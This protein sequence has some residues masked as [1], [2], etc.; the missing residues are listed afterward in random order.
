MDAV[1][2]DFKYLTEDITI[3]NI[4]TKAKKEISDI[5][6]NARLHNQL[7]KDV[8]TSIGKIHINPYGSVSQISFGGEDIIDVDRF[9]VSR[10]LNIDSNNFYNIQKDIEEDCSNFDFYPIIYRNKIFY[11]VLKTS[12]YFRTKFG[13]FLHEHDILTVKYAHKY[14]IFSL[15][16]DGHIKDYIFQC[17]LLS[18][19]NTE[20]LC[21]KDAG[22]KF[23]CNT[24]LYYCFAS[25]SNYLLKIGQCKQD[26]IAYKESFDYYE[27]TVE[28]VVFWISRIR[29]NNSKIKMKDTKRKAEKLLIE[30]QY[31]SISNFCQLKK[32]VFKSL[33]S[34]FLG[35]MSD[36]KY[37]NGDILTPTRLIEI[38]NIEIDISDK[39]LLDR[40]LLKAILY[41]DIPDL[42]W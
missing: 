8:E 17:G 20:Q 6:L 31:D 13:F 2:N 11:T 28:S 4:I 39:G 12:K 26:F 27:G 38:L 19:E 9:I 10:S 22:K 29:D 37:E 35:E 42:C 24:N 23:G 3:S 40:N 25:K 32:I 7:D 15:N 41:S 33:S 14:I 21:L 18:Q 5:L 30:I 34:Y 1:N 36:I 16:R